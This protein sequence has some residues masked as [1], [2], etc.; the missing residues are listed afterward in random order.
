MP[1]D[2]LSDV[3]TSSR[4][5]RVVTELGGSVFFHFLSWPVFSQHCALLQPL[6]SVID[7]RIGVP[8]ETREKMEARGVRPEKSGLLQA[9]RLSPK[10]KSRE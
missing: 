2:P 9:S 4:V 3:G 8:E 10:H 5:G 1:P 6:V 7:L